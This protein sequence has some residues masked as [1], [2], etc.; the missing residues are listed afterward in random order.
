MHI[1]SWAENTSNT[2]SIT[3]LNQQMQSQQTIMGHTYLLTVDVE[4]HTYTIL[5]QKAVLY[6]DA[7]KFF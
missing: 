4:K 6:Y 5:Y 1:A 7:G 2:E 3:H